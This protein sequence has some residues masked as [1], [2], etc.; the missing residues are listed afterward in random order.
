MDIQIFVQLLVNGLAMGGIYVLVSTGFALVYGTARVFNFAHGHFYMLGA[1]IYG[2]LIFLGVHWTLSIV[3]TALAGAFLGAITWYLIF[4]PLI[5]DVFLSVTAALGLGLIIVHG[6]IVTV[7]ERDIIVP[8]VFPGVS[9]IGGVAIPF[10]KI[11]VV[12]FS[13]AVML[14]L[15]YFLRTR[16]GYALE[17]TTIDEDAASLQGINTGQ[18]FLIAMI[19]GSA[20]AGIAGAVIVPCLTAQAHMGNQIVIIFISVVVLAGHGSI[21]GAVII[22][23]LFGLVKSFGYYYLGTLDSVL[24]ML[25]VAIIMYIKPWGIWGVEFRRTV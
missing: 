25:V 20:M 4:K 18:I 9:N 22:G 21:K 11:A 1:F 13:L 23:L 12:G 2:G 5:H 16:T 24:L 17:A 19:V 14:A 15:Y 10:E 3:L 6:I 8:S 7:G